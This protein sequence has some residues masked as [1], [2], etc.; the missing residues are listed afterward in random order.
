M[1]Y[2]DILE[3]SMYSSKEVIESAYRI[4]KGKYGIENSEINKEKIGMLDLAYETLI[5]DKKREQYNAII[6][7]I[8]SNIDFNT[9]SNAAEVKTKLIINWINKIKN[10]RKITGILMALL[11]TFSLV[12]IGYIQYTKK[13]NERKI[14]EQKL[15]EL[16]KI[17]EKN[18][19]EFVE[20]KT[21]FNEYRKAFSQTSSEIKTL[22]MFAYF[23]CSNYS[24]VWGNAINSNK[25]FSKE[26]D[27][28]SEENRANGV[29]EEVVR[30]K[31]S[32][33]GNMQKLQNPPVEFIKTYDMLL[34]LY[35]KCDKL[36]NYSISPSGTYEFYSKE[37]PKLYNDGE[38]IYSKIKIQIPSEK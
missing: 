35:E 33:I 7:A 16:Q 1:N 13:T 9:L 4:L 18:N 28:V 27:K 22:M 25:D 36:Y 14:E 12:G 10:M 34:I 26:L 21:K 19:A 32:I 17:E 2:Y 31:N 37:T 3:V 38:T 11:L 5:D 6:A 23:R 8:N 29:L 20:A 30:N 24:D 15:V